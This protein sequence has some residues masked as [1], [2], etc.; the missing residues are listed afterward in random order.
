MCFPLSVPREAIFFERENIILSRTYRIEQLVWATS[1]LAIAFL[2]QLVISPESMFVFRFSCIGTLHRSL[3]FLSIAPDRNPLSSSALRRLFEPASGLVSQK[4]H[5]LSNYMFSLI[6]LKTP[7]I[8]S[9]F[10]APPEILLHTGPF[11]ELYH[12]YSHHYL[13]PPLPPPGHWPPP[14]IFVEFA[15]QQVGLIFPV[16]QV[17]FISCHNL[18]AREVGFPFFY[19]PS[20]LHENMTFLFA[21]TKWRPISRGRVGTSNNSNNAQI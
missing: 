19:S 8:E 16:L 21:T 13:H 2:P 5:H 14:P 17:N 12:A 9:S 15:C 18:S 3:Y 11:L 4:L 10:K 6:S 7:S 1:W 20:W